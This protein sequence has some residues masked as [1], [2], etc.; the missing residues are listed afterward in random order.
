MPDPPFAG[1]AS[2]LFQYGEFVNK[3]NTLLCQ[4]CHFGCLALDNL[5]A[6]VF[7]VSSQ[8]GNWG[9][10]EKSFTFSSQGKMLQIRKCEWL[11]SLV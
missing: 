5:H 10:H 1:A 4:L 3:A 9:N 8:P 11:D 6:Q 7:R 2:L